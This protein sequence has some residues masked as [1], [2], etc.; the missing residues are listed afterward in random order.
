LRTVEFLDALA[1]SVSN[2][3]SYDNYVMSAS[4]LLRLQDTYD[5]QTTN[6]ASGLVAGSTSM[7]G[8]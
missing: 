6:I 8:Q 2:F 3:P 5:L 4:A 7:T 1:G